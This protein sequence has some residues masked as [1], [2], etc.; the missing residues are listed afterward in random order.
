MKSTE[1]GLVGLFALLGDFDMANL[2]T[3][4]RSKRQVLLDSK[5]IKE[6]YLRHLT[7]IQSPSIQSIQRF[8]G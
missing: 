2:R 4:S 7:T 5:E 6:R 3:R 1:V 8:L